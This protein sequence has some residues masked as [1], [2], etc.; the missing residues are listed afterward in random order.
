MW[1]FHQIFESLIRWLSPVISF[2]AEEAWRARYPH[3]GT[4]IHEE[5]FQDLP[6]SWLSPELSDKVSTWRDSRRVLTGALEIARNEKMIGSSLAAHLDI[7]M[8]SE[9]QN[10]L[11]D[12]DIAELAIVSSFTFSTEPAPQNAFSLEDVAGIHVIVSPAS[13]EKCARCWKVLPEV[14]KS[15]AHPDLCQRC[16]EAVQAYDKRNS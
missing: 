11:K 10:Q 7:Y 8:D 16:E 1:T 15:L 4:S 6:E 14:G 13:G 9:W 3:C 5:L 2:T 12:V